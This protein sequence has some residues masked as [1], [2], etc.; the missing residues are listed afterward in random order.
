M[1]TPGVR[2]R[3][4]LYAPHGPGAVALL[5][6][7]RSG[8]PAGD[9]TELR[10]VEL[11]GPAAKAFD[12]NSKMQ[13]KGQTL[14]WL[15]TACDGQPQSM[16]ARQTLLKSV[17][18]VLLFAS[19]AADVGNLESA[20]QGDFDQ[21]AGKNYALVVVAPDEASAKG[22]QQLM[23]TAEPALLLKELM[24]AALKVAAASM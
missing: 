24:K 19:A 1:S 5:E 23:P 13:L 12:Y 15:L 3:L 22:H 16:I 17:H 10:A 14:E 2:I 4:V 7:M 9:V 6:K 11:E 18:G 21:I 8:L 20:L